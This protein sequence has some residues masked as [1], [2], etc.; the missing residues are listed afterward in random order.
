MVSAVTRDEAGR[1][2]ED[3]AALA[4]P[5]RLLMLRHLR[6]GPRSAGYLA[7]AVG[8]PQ[9]LAA[10]HL[11]VLLDAGLITKRRKGQFSCYAADRDRVK[12]LHRRIGKLVGAAGAVAERRPA[13]DDPC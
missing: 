9:P 1:L 12:E 7:H 3:L 5:H 11:S 6:R 2:S 4:E 8:M 13:A 10:Y